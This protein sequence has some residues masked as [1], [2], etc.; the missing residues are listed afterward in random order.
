MDYIRIQGEDEYLWNT[1]HQ[2]GDWMG[3]DAADG[4]YTGRTA[5]D[6]I[7][8][9]FYA[10]SAHLTA[11]AAAVLRRKDAHVKYETIYK[12]VRRAFGTEFV[13][14]NGRLTED[15]QT[16]YALARYF[17]MID[18]KKRAIT[19]LSE[20]IEENGNCLNT[21]FVGAPYLCHALADNGR[22]DLAYSLLL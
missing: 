21:G 22:A 19:R 14:P 15:T 17:D 11:K 6:F 16:A 2:F 8:T 12:N 18:N 1:G 5:K 3:L 20:F 10:H 7:A 9:V 13:T 4:A